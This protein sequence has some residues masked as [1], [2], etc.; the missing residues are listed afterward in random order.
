MEDRSGEFIRILKK[1]YGI[2]GEP[3]D[4]YET[5]ESGFEKQRFHAGDKRY[6]LVHCK[7]NF[8]EDKKLISEMVNFEIITVKSHELIKQLLPIKDYYLYELIP[9]TV[10]GVPDW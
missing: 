1:H 6:N 4:I 9:Y 7:K 8:A 10:Q 2:S 3:D 5:F